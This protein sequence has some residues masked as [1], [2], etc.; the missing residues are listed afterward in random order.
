[1][2]PLPPEQLTN[3]LGAHWVKAPFRQFLWY[4]IVSAKKEVPPVHAAL[5]RPRICGFIIHLQ[6]CFTCSTQVRSFTLCNASWIGA[7]FVRQS[8][9]VHDPLTQ[10]VLE[11]LVSLSCVLQHHILFSVIGMMPSLQIPSHVQRPLIAVVCKPELA[12]QF[13]ACSQPPL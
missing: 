11:I 8:F 4:V 6:Y 13:S 1:M 2:H 9:A 5:E 7:R 3:T 10:L 12:A